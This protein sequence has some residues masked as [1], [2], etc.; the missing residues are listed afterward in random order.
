MLLLL[1]HTPLGKILLC[2]RNY[3]KFLYSLSCTETTKK[4]NKNCVQTTE[5]VCWGLSRAVHELTLMVMIR[6]MTKRGETK[7]MYHSTD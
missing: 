7:A 5:R 4:E 3:V 6:L 2:Q 1:D